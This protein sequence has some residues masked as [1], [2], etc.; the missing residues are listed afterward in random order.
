MAIDMKLN[1]KHRD[2]QAGDG[3]IVLI[4][5]LALIG[6]GIWW[7]YSHKTAMDKEGRAFGRQMIE[8][9]TVKHDKAFWVNNMG[10]QCRIDNPPSAQE[11]LIT[12]LTEMGAPAQPIK[13]DEQMTWES[14]FFEPKGYFTAHLNYPGRGATM[15]IAISHPVSRW[16]LDNVTF[17]P[18]RERQ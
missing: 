11:A 1:R 16:Q 12:Q 8:A 2:R 9:L 13:I 15:Q 10:P 3:L 18:E 5:F 4:I 14:Q 7:L 17:A 6:G